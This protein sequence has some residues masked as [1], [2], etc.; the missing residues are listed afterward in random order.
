MSDPQNQGPVPPATTTAAG[1]GGVGGMAG[2]AADPSTLAATG[3]IVAE[4]LAVIAGIIGVFADPVTGGVRA[5]LLNLTDTV[6]VGDVAVLGIAIAL[7]LLTPDPPGGLR[8]P[9]LLQLSALLSAII[10]ISGIVRAITLLS[11]SGSGALRVDGFVA[12]IGVAIA[13]ATLAFYA[14]TQSFLKKQYHANRAA[15]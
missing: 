3:L 14:A 11:Q 12:T 1:S 10:S 8:R 7:L 15:A 9:L 4:I 5:R 6:D 2:M 13:A